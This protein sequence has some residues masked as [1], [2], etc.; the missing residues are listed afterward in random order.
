MAMVREEAECIGLLV[1]LRV[2]LSA[3]QATEIQEAPTPYE[4]SGL[5]FYLAFAERSRK[6]E[7]HQSST[8]FAINSSR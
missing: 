1:M 3:T 2:L 6:T 7:T 4:E 5:L 8:S